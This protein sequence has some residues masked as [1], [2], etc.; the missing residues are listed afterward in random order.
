[1]AR[2]TLGGRRRTRCCCADAQRVE[3]APLPIGEALHPLRCWPRRR[4]WCSTTGGSSRAR[5]RRAGADRQAQRR[6][7]ALAGARWCCR[8]S[9]AWACTW[10]R[11]GARRRPQSCARA[12]RGVCRRRP[13]WSSRRQAGARRGRRRL[14]RAWSVLSDDVT[15]RGRSDRSGDA[16][17]CCGPWRLARVSCAR[18]PL[19]RV[20]AGARTRL[21]DERPAAPALADVVQAGAAPAQ[22]A[23]LAAA[24]DAGNDREV[25]EQLRALA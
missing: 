19:G 3:G 10:R 9:S 14:V 17:G 12:V 13:G 22:V 21:D 4:C 5:G 18:V 6:G 8:R 2:C 1:M 7:R 24:L 25:S 23:A 16:A 11:G 15:H 20:T